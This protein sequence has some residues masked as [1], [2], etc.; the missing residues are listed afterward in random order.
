MARVR[1]P[2]YKERAGIPAGAR[3]HRWERFSGR[4]RV[5]GSYPEGSGGFRPFR[6]RR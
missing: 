6:G 4:R 5:T 2:E 3:L 1:G